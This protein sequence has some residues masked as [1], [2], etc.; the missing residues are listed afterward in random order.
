MKSF[1][2]YVLLYFGILAA[3]LIIDFLITIISLAIYWN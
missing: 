2:K 3:I 1:F